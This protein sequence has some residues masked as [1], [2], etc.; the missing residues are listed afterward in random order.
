MTRTRPTAAPFAQLRPAS[1]EPRSKWGLGGGPGR[2]GPMK[3]LMQRL[4]AVDT[5]TSAAVT[6]T[7][8]FDTF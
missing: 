5:D 6:V 2:T 8:Y 7:A 3:E 4:S 1:A